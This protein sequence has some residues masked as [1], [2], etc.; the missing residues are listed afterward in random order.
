MRPRKTEEGQAEMALSAVPSERPHGKGLA[1][2]T[3]VLWLHQSHP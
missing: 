2:N 3:P 1:C